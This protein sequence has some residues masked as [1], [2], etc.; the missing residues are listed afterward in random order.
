MTKLAQDAGCPGVN[1]NI[2]EVVGGLSRRC[3][4]GPSVFR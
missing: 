4:C 2:P 1:I 3:V